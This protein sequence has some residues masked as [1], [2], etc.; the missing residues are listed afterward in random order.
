MELVIFVLC[1]NRYGSRWVFCNDSEIIETTFS[2]SS[3]IKFIAEKSFYPVCV[4]YS[5]S[6]I[7]NKMNTLGPMNPSLS[8]PVKSSVSEKPSELSQQIFAACDKVDVPR[9][10]DPDNSGHSQ[11]L[12]TGNLQSASGQDIYIL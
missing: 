4:C 8:Q 9:R 10:H 1:Y 2:S 11:N 5:L 3:L 12:D 6:R 7:G